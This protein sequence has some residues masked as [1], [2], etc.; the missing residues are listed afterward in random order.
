MFYK[1]YHRNPTSATHGICQR[2]ELDQTYFLLFYTI[3]LTPDCFHCKLMY[4]ICTYCLLSWVPN[5]WTWL[6]E[7]IMSLCFVYSVV[8]GTVLHVIIIWCFT[9][10]FMTLLIVTFLE[11]CINILCSLRFILFVWARI[12]LLCCWCCCCQCVILMCH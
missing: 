10:I 5:V 7:K 2:V 12:T 11:T 3:V 1:F 4:V 8:T 6:E 9:I